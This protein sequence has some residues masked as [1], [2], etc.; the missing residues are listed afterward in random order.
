MFVCLIPP[1]LRNKTWFKSKNYGCY[2]LTGGIDYW[3]RLKLQYTVNESFL[4]LELCFLYVYKFSLRFWIR[5]NFTLMRLSYIRQCTSSFF[6]C[7]ILNAWEKCC[8]FRCSILVGL[9]PIDTD[10]LSIGIDLCVR[11]HCDRFATVYSYCHLQVKMRH[12]A[13]SI[14]CAPANQ[15]AMV[16][17][18]ERQQNIYPNR[19]DTK[20]SRWGQ[21]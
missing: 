5:F 19:S 18:V 21:L 13:G 2:V 6:V 1:I 8:S 3:V 10:N 16:V 9:G 20:R 15:P 7:F 4:I 17:V 14:H 11:D 12:F